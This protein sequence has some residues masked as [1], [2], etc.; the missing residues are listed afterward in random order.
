[1]T[2]D[3]G[4]IDLPAPD[5]AALKRA[6]QAALAELRRVPRVQPWR[7]RALLVVA[8]AAATTALGA[9]VI[10][11]LNWPLPA[12]A[13]RGPGVA[14][15]LA[16]QVV[17]LWAALVP[18][19]SRL[20]PLSW[21]LGA[22]GAAAV[23]VARATG[24]A[25]WDTS[26]GWVCTVTELLAALV[27]MVV[28]V[29]GLRDGAWSWR[30]AVTAGVALGAAGGIWGEVACERGLLHVVVHHGGAW[31]LLVVAV[32]LLSRRMRPRSFVP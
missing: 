1:M 17:G 11:A 21:L 26:A 10:A 14:L 7:R 12:P 2:F 23:L 27:P 31:L 18:G 19:R 28:V 22:A 29:G 5:Q 25:G 24:T 32:V 3:D 6:R 8:L 13:A 30:R 15:L 20:A 16:A 9:L 4:D